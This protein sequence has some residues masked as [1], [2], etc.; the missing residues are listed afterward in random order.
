MLEND[1]S[2]STLPLAHGELS[3]GDAAEL[4]ALKNQIH[5]A[6]GL[7]CELYKEKCLRRRL[8]VRMRALGAHTYSEYARLLRSD[9]PEYQ[10]L[11]DIVTIN[12]SKFF[13]NP[14]VWDVVREQ[15]L[16]GLFATPAARLNLWSAGCASG[17][18]PYT[19]S[20]LFQEY[21]ET[22]DHRIDHLRV[23]GTDIDREV[24]A[25]AVRAQYP[26][27]AMTDMS[28]DTIARWFEP[29]DGNTLK[30]EARRNVKFAQ[31]DLIKDEFPA[32]QHMICCRNVI[33]YFERSL[34]EDLFERFHQ[35]LLP[36]GILVLG[37]VEAMFGKA[38]SMFRPISN[39]QRVFRRI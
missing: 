18:E 16:P 22:H 37:K 34:Q 12:V 24:L 32:K 38:A 27:F 14:E 15:V 26:P 2:Q 13:R 21:A 31:L 10:R 19:L 3:E 6:V 35:S 1:R 4:T 33:I 20:M 7:N 17:E 29:G 28:R 36:G 5:V 8:A 23:L 30:P 39:R 9:E 11:L 25:A